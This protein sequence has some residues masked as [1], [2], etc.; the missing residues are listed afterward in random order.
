[1][2]VWIKLVQVTRGD[3]LSQVAIE[4]L[5]PRK[6]TRNTHQPLSRVLYRKACLRAWGY[7]V[8]S[9]PWHDWVLLGDAEDSLCAQ[10]AKEDYLRELLAPLSPS[11]VGEERDV[12]SD[13]SALDEV[14]VSAVGTGG[15]S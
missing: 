13:S 9:V 7:A 15:D 3:L 8:L 1:M 14:F 4:I 5:S 6:M 11:S 12:E 10:K 2:S